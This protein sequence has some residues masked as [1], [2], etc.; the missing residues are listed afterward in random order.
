MA[1][2]RTHDFYRFA[3]F[4]AGLAI[5]IGAV[6]ATFGVALVAPL[7]VWVVHRFQR[8]R[9]RPFG[10]WPSW[11][12]AVSAV[13][14]ALVFVAGVVVSRL[15]AGTWGHIRQTA[16]SASVEAAK[17]PPPAWL[18]RLAPGAAARSMPR[19]SP[20]DFNT[21]TMI[22]GGGFVLGFLGNVIGTIGWVGTMLLVFSVS[23]RWLRASAAAAIES[24]VT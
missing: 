12:S 19:S 10:A 9:G 7:G 2:S 11:I 20:R 3:A 14:I 17:Q 23:G 8:S 13:L 6:R 5:L 24:D 22:L 18:D 15:P 1:Q 21:L 16:D 4:L